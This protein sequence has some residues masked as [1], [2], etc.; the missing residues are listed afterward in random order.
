MM[1]F[2]DNIQSDLRT[3][4][5]EN[6]QQRRQIGVRQME[7]RLGQPCQRQHQK[8]SGKDPENRN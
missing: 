2:K 8:E 4:C 6:F 5:I 7:K 1:N 3:L